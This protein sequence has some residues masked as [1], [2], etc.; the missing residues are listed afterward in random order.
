VYHRGLHGLSNHPASE[1]IPASDDPE[2]I[3]G[4]L[5]QSFQKPNRF[6]SPQN[7]CGSNLDNKLKQESRAI[8]NNSR[9]LSKEVINNIE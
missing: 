4:G 5:V 3:I 8:A 9:G 7:R 1:A 2:E 6:Q